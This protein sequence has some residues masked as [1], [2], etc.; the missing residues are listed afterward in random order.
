MTKTVS[1]DEGLIQYIT[2]LEVP[3]IAESALIILERLAVD[4]F[5]VLLNGQR[6]QFRM[7]PFTN[8][9]EDA[10]KFKKRLNGLI[11]SRGC[12][13]IT[14]LIGFMTDH[15]GYHIRGYC[16]HSAGFQSS[17]FAL[18]IAKRMARSLD[19][20]VRLRWIRSIVSAIAELHKHGM[21][22]GPMTTMTLRIIPDPHKVVMDPTFSY[23]STSTTRERVATEVWGST[24]GGENAGKVLE[25]AK[26]TDVYQIG[27]V[28]WQIAKHLYRCD[29][30]W[31]ARAFCE[32][33]SWTSMPRY[34]CKADHTRPR[35]LP[36]CQDAPG[37]I[38]D[39]IRLCHLEDWKDRPSVCT[40]LDLLSENTDPSAHEARLDPE[41]AWYVNHDHPGA[42]AMNC[43]KCHDLTSLNNDCHYH[44]PVCFGDD[45]DLCRQCYEKHGVRCLDQ[46]HGTIKN[47]AKDGV[48][49]ESK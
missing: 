9:T 20:T 13:G 44:C 7:A 42:R 18:G 23:R 33:A 48:F 36:H 12:P 22:I 35:E 37:L 41:L 15:D 17:G 21:V 11:R 2:R 38:N 10:Q 28:I 32:K 47:I 31:C 25:V 1:A 24:S 45:F 27:L 46:N 29:I 8:R 49:H 40:L 16:S 6:C 39:M 34:L 5:R 4:H 26:A 3:K 43:D 19:W 30:K 14:Q